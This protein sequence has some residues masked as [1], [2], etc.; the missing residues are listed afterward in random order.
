MGRKGE[1]LAKVVNQKP[2]ISTKF[3]PNNEKRDGMNPRHP[4]CELINQPFKITQFK[5]HANNEQSIKVPQES[6]GV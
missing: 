2:I 5:A 1:H 3:L 4:V 6:K